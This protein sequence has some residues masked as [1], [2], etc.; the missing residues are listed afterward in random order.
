MVVMSATPAARS[1]CKL[2]LG[3]GGGRNSAGRNREVS[4]RGRQNRGVDPSGNNLYLEPLPTS[5]LKR[6]T[7]RHSRHRSK[8]THWV[9]YPEVK[10]PHLEKD[11]LTALPLQ[12]AAHA[13]PGGVLHRCW[14]NLLGLCSEWNCQCFL[15]SSLHRLVTLLF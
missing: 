6:M 12:D 9:A 5:V 10:L 3:R 8:E 15:L 14:R 13:H 11:S 1:A 7:A 4:E 2:V